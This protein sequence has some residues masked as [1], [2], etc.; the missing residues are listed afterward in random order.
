MSSFRKLGYNM[1]IEVHYLQNH[2]DYFPANL[3][4]FSEEQGE[5]FHQ[6]IKKTLHTQSISFRLHIN[7]VRDKVLNFK[8]SQ[9]LAEKS[10][11]FCFKH[12]FKIEKL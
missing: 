9:I 2:L 8:N 10:I 12:G 6:D 11:K 1:S 5:R 7:C 3:G 4:D